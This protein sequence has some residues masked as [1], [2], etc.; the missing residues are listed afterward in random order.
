[1]KGMKKQK[2]RKKHPLP[3]K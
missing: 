1:M 3:R 2:R